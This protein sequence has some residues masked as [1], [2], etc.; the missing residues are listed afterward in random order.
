M[1]APRAA[2]RTRWPATACTAISTVAATLIRVVEYEKNLSGSN[3]GRA[4]HANQLPTS[5]LAMVTAVTR[6]TALRSA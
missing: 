6:R 5:A 4:S 2:G 1:T 3:A